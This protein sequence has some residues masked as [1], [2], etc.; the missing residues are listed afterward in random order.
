MLDES[1]LLMPHF[2]GALSEPGARAIIEYLRGT[3]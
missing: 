3:P 1:K 2:R